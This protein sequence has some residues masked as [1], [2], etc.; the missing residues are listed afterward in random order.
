MLFQLEKQVHNMNNDH[1]SLSVSKIH[2]WIFGKYFGV[3]KYNS[4]CFLQAFFCLYS[5]SENR[6]YMCEQLLRRIL[7]LNR[8][9]CNLK[10]EIGTTKK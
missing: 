3:I 2:I 6:L 9:T 7:E 5:Y 4:L 8:N 10:Q 1:G